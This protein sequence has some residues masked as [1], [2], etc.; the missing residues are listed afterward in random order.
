MGLVET[1][2]CTLKE[3]QVFGVRTMLSLGGRDA[4]KVSSRS[5]RFNKYLVDSRVQ[6]YFL[7]RGEAVEVLHYFGDA[8]WEA[9]AKFCNMCRLRKTFATV[10]CIILL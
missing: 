2:P 1:M 10:S 6:P 3:G 9:V 4:G 5:T 8:L 7:V